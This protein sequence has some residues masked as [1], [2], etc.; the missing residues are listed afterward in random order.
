MHF[1]QSQHGKPIALGAKV[2]VPHPAG[3]AAG[4]SVTVDVAFGKTGVAPIT[5]PDNYA[6]T[7]QPNQPAFAVVSK[8]ST[9]FRVTLSPPNAKATLAEGHFDAIVV[10]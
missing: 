6:V 5:I 1:L 10:R 8:S 4:A 9:G 3:A 2:R 7:V